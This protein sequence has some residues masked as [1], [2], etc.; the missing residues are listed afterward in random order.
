MVWYFLISSSMQM[1]SKLTGLGSDVVLVVALGFFCFHDTRDWEN[2]CTGR[3]ECMAE[4]ENG[5][6][7][8]YVCTGLGVWQNGRMNTWQECTQV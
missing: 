3:F 4:W 7:A 6:M 1:S 2:I 8:R 5:N